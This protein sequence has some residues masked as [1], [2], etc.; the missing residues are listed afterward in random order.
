MSRQAKRHLSR[1][2]R[3]MIVEHELSKVLPV[4]TSTR[5]EVVDH[6]E[7]HDLLV[8]LEVGSN[9]STSELSVL[10]ERVRL[11]L[12]HLQRQN[13]DDPCLASWSATFERGGERL[14]IVSVLD[15]AVSWRK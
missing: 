6:D 7:I 3:E 9:M 12:V 8:F 10:A 15:R 4:T 13:P 14:A 2:S 1:M 11:F 5:I